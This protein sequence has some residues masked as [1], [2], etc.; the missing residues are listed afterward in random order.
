MRH[1]RI[2][3]PVRAILVAA[4]LLAAFLPSCSKKKEEPK[5]EAQSTENVTIEG[6]AKVPNLTLK[7]LDGTEE[8]LSNYAGKI[9][10]L[11]IWATWNKDCKRQVAALNELYPTLRRTPV[12]LLGVAMDENGEQA[13]RRFLQKTPISYPVFYNGQEVVRHLGGVRKLPTTYIILRDG[14][15]YERL[16]GF[17]SEMFFEQKLEEMKEGRL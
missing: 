10:I 6:Y 7:A 11:N 13:L 12:V 8:R 17:Q 1:A 15:L 14:S 4:A 9:V 2:I 5:S 3:R 16:L